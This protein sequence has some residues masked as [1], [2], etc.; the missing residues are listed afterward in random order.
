MEFT[1]ARVINDA[2]RGIIALHSVTTTNAIHHAFQSATRADTRKFLLLQNASFLPMF[3]EAARARGRL[4]DRN[5]MLMS[6]KGEKSAAT[7]TVPETFELMGNNRM[8]AA[9]KLYGY[10]SMMASAGCC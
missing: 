6:P 5:I 8:A 10:L 7:E 9:E 1:P 4:V 2:Q 3:R